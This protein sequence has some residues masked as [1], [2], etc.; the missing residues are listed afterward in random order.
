MTLSNPDYLKLYIQVFSN[1]NVFVREE[2]S[3]FSTIHWSWNRINS[4][5]DLYFSPFLLYKGT[6]RNPC[7]NSDTGKHVCPAKSSFPWSLSFTW[8]RSIASSGTLKQNSNSSFQTGNQLSMMTFVLFLAT[9]PGI[10]IIRICYTIHTQKYFC[11]FL[12]WGENN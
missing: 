10:P 9:S 7:F 11:F 5:T 3:L 12:L 6:E 4:F 1:K 2:W 8:I